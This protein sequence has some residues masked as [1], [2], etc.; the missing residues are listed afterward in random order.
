M[1]FFRLPLVL[2]ATTFITAALADPTGVTGT[3]ESVLLDLDAM[4]AAVV[5]LASASIPTYELTFFSPPF[6]L[7]PDKDTLNSIIVDLPNTPQTVSV[8]YY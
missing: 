7:C 2:L 6:T 1:H 8:S 4:G 3:A 5:S